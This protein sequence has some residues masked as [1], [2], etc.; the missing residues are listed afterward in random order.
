MTRLL[1]V[2]GS[3][4]AAS[5][6]RQLLAAAAVL[7]PPA[8]TVVAFDGLAAIPPFNEDDE[9]GPAPTAVARWRAAI[10]RADALLIATP[11]YNGSVPGQLKNALDWASRPRGRAALD[12]VPVA[13]L[14]AGPGPRGAAD[15]QDDLRR[16]LSRARAQV[17]GDPLVVGRAHERFDATGGLADVEV[18]DALAR[19]L[20]VLAAAVAPAAAA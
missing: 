19:Q 1:T 15:A 7:A 18:A 20:A 10:T 2:A 14:S 16:V 9:A 13:T 17:L 3:L 8:V 5:V 4:R 6:N 12:G 11:E